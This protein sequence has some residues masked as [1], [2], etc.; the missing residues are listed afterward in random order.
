MTTVTFAIAIPVVV[1]LALGL[2]QLTLRYL[3]DYAYTDLR[4]EVRLFRRFAIY[5]IAWCDLASVA[6]W[7]F[8]RGALAT[9]FTTL[10]LG[11]RVFGRA[12]VLE[13]RGRFPRFVVI[14]PADAD[15]VLLELRARVARTRTS[16]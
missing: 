14:T 3:Y 6:P 13:R 7:R 15:R 1:A 10:S 12:I 9:A 16:A 8:S 2:A 11:N 5:G 4:F